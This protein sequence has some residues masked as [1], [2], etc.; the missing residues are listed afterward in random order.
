MIWWDLL[1]LKDFIIYEIVWWIDKLYINIFY[2]FNLLFLNILVNIK[3]YRILF[4]IYIIWFFF[5]YE[6]FDFYLLLLVYCVKF[7]FVWCLWF[8]YL[9]IIGENYDFY[10]W[11]GGDFFFKIFYLGMRVFIGGF[12]LIMYIVD[13]IFIYCKIEMLI[14]ILWYNYV[15]N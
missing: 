6:Y 8:V 1:K 15:R 10:W 4:Y 5:E 13:V 9:L 2:F 3:I 12:M 11:F 7:G 14:G